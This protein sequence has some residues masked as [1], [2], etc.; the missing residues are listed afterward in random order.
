MVQAGL[1]KLLQVEKVEQVDIAAEGDE[2]ID[3]ASLPL[4]SADIGPEQAELPYPIT[5]FDLRLA[6]PDDVND[7]LFAHRRL[8]TQKKGRRNGRPSFPIISGSS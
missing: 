4:L 7:F 2:D 3:V 1:Q 5:G 8:L 6:A